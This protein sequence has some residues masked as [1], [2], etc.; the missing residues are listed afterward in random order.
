MENAHH[1]YHQLI[2]RDP[3][4]FH[5]QIFLPTP[6]IISKFTG[7][8]K[9]RRRRAKGSR[10]GKGTDLGLSSG[11]KSA[12]PSDGSGS[13]G[14][15]AIEEKERKMKRWSGIESRSFQLNKLS[16]FYCHSFTPQRRGFLWAVLYFWVRQLGTC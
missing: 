11:N 2:N 16:L 6:H 3:N 14:R 4:F 12:F 8:H 5:Q 13:T 15:E 10:F 9:R 1:A 7:K